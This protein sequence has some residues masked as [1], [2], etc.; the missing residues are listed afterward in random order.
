MNEP[1]IEAKVKLNDW[2]PEDDEMIFIANP[3]TE[4]VYARFESIVEGN[5]EF[6]AKMR[7]LDTFVI[8]Q[9][10][11]LQRM[12][13]ITKAINYFI[14]F[15]D[16]NDEFLTALS[17]LKR[18]VDDGTVKHVKDYITLLL[19]NMVTPSMVSKVRNMVNDLY[20]I[21]IEN[22][23]SVGYTSTPKLTNEDAKNILVLSYFFRL[24]L[25]ITIHWYNRPDTIGVENGRNYIQTFVCIFMSVCTAI[26]ED[27]LNVY[28]SIKQLVS[29]RIGRKYNSDMII[30]D[31]KKEKNGA[32]DA[33]YCKELADEIL[34][35]KSLYKIDYSQSVVSYIDGIVRQNYMQYNI[36]NFKFKTVPISAEEAIKDS[37]DT[38]SIIEAI[39][40]ANFKVNGENHIFAEAN[41][42]H[43]MRIIRRRFNID[44]P[45]DEFE[46]YMENIQF[47]A[48][49]NFF[50]CSFYNKFFMDTTF[51]SLLTK[52]DSIYLLII[53]KKFLQ[54][55]GMRIIPHICTAKSTSR[56]RD[57]AIKN[58]KF[59]EKFEESPL[60]NEIMKNTYSYI[61]EIST[62]TDI[63]KRYISMIINSQFTLVDFD[64]TINDRTFADVNQDILIDEFEEFISISF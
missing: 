30:H 39:G 27:A 47:N 62:K 57:N 20:S 33:S 46:F 49:T 17:S 44:I 34:L 41:I 48:L 32:T 7:L 8:K 40:N 26:G 2:I 43:T 22:E 10:H 45:E 13:D 36:E 12:D 11:Y 16:D 14:R 60:N 59:N 19:H 58:R 5:E 24:I 61:S 55:N 38:I 25:P 29:H 52:R 4:T 37:D 1:G 51:I 9:H 21:N 31:K 6:M 63:I 18:F 42:I 3:V 54:L 56:F 15:Y 35:V 64:E 50:I 28:I 23:K 53:M